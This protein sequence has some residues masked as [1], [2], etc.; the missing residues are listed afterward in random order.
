MVV[1]SH[2]A[3]VAATGAILPLAASAISLARA[4][5]AS[6]ARRAGGTLGITGA[7]AVGAVCEAVA[8]VVDAVVANLGHR[9][10]AV[11]VAVT[12]V[13]AAFAQPIAAAGGGR[14]QEAG[15]AIHGAIA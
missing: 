4:R 8:I 10:S 15:I 5:T 6:H 3:R 12:T 2:G 14:G 9:R 7:I 1:I 13:F 11:R